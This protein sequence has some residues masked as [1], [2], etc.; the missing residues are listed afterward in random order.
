MAKLVWQWL[1][2]GV[3]PAEQFACIKTMLSQNRIVM[4]TWLGT[5]P[6]RL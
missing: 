5:N 3:H 1:Q 4:P 2:G 6:N